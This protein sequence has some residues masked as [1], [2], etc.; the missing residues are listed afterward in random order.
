MCSKH[1]ASPNGPRIVADKR[2]PE[3]GFSRA[4]DSP[5]PALETIADIVPLEIGGAR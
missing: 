5:A 3:I 1:K 2:F 4:P